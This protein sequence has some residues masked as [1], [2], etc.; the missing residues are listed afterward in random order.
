MSN[1]LGQ[2]TKAQIIKALETLPTGLGE[3]LLLTIERIKSQDPHSKT[4][5]TLAL[6]ILM[7]LS[8]A[9]RPLTVR[10]L[11]HA[12]ATDPEGKRLG[13]ITHSDFF[14]DCCFGLVII[15]ETSIIRL[16]HFSVS[17][18]LEER[19]EDL[20]NCSDPILATTCLSYMLFFVQSTDYMRNKRSSTRAYPDW[21][22]LDYSI[23]YWAVHGKKDRSQ[24]DNLPTF[25]LKAYEFCSSHSALKFWV[26]ASKD[27]S[28][29]SSRNENRDWFFPFKYLTSTLSKI[30]LASI[31]GLTSIV[32]HQVAKRPNSIGSR[33]ENGATPLMLAAAGGYLDITELLMSNSQIDVNA[34]DKNGK[35]A[36]WYAVDQEKWSIVRQMLNRT[37]DLDINLGGPFGRLCEKGTRFQGDELNN[38]ISLFLTRDGLDV[39]VNNALD[40]WEP[41]YRL[42]IYYRLELLAELVAYPTFDPWRNGRPSRR[43][44]DYSN[45]HKRGDYLPFSDMCDVPAITQLLD[46]D[47]RFDFC[48]F[49]ALEIMWPFVYYAFADLEP[50]ELRRIDWMDIYYDENQHWKYMV[51]DALKSRRISAKTTDSKGRSFLHYLARVGEDEDRQGHLEFLLKRLPTE[52]KDEQGRTALHVAAESGHEHVIRQLLKAGADPLAIDEEGMSVLHYATKS[53]KIDLV[54]LLIEVGANVTAKARYGESLLHM[55]TNSSNS[56]GEMIHLLIGLGVPIGDEDESGRTPLHVA[57]YGSPEVFTALLEH[58]A[59]PASWNC[60]RGTPLIDAVAENNA[61]LTRL[62]LSKYKGDW[63][64]LDCY[65]MSVFDYLSIQKPSVAE[66][67]GFTPFHW[68]NYKPVEEDKRRRRVLQCLRHRLELMISSNDR[69]RKML[70]WR[71]AAQLLKLGDDTAARIMLEADIMPESKSG[72][73]YF[74]NDCCDVCTKDEGILFKCKTCPLKWICQEC[75]ERTDPDKGELPLCADH[76]LLQIPGDDW[77]NHPNG[78]VNQQG[79]AFGEWLVELR[80]KY[81]AMD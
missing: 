50:A 23:R 34:Q 76:D 64:A 15:D 24:N 18:F 37:S 46:N 27:T 1:I 71:T 16:V 77:K 75:R 25:N 70:A 2:T 31:Y 29:R 62:C 72:S 7:W 56:V 79:Q 55:A 53:N 73:P 80:E 6:K 35:T 41:W 60:K 32:Q 61:A 69:N 12:V 42:A 33:D 63:N 66:N 13:D 3:N 59:D 4:R 74:P 11:Q 28:R 36:L 78:T 51:R 30:H 45:Y 65:G 8:S 48:D 52:L 38:L 54:R 22:F 26:R 40:G 58:G 39:N 43:H 5:A 20:F 49:Y 10:E 47:R 81:T 21:P 9:R 17:E 57:C 68:S 44:L 67:L 14:V 19:R